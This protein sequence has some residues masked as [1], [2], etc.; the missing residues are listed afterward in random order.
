[1]KKSD[2]IAV[3]VIVSI[4]VVGL[5]AL[6][7]GPY[8]VE[9]AEGNNNYVIRITG[10]DNTVTDGA[11]TLMVP[12]PVY[13][14]GEPVFSEAN[15][16]RVRAEPGVYRLN[17]DWNLSVETTPYGDM[18][19]FR[20]V[21]GE[22]S[23]IDMILAAFDRESGPRLLMPVVSIPGNVSVETFARNNY[24]KYQSVVYADGLRLSADTSA[25]FDLRYIGGGGKKLA[26]QAPVWESSV[27]ASLPGGNVGFAEAA[28]TYSVSDSWY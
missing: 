11:A 25:D 10:M 4:A 8:L 13:L 21:S 5:A 28:V 6:L 17:P 23:D 26:F 19:V 9:G 20:S 16:A 18:L 2:G 24:G 22:V 27:R 15:L 12:I 7:C 14:S 3:A 1:M